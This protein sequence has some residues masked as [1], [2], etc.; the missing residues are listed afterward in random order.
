MS[1]KLKACPCESCVAMAVGWA[2]TDC[3]VALDKGNDPRKNDLA[4]VLERA[5]RDLNTRAEPEPSREAFVAEF[6]QFANEMLHELTRK[7]F[8]SRTHLIAIRMAEMTLSKLTQADDAGE[9]PIKCSCEYMPSGK[10]CLYC[11]ESIGLTPPE[12]GE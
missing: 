1:E 2:Y 10:K 5:K 4:D 3:C 8:D 12:G 6:V 7:D 11:L 9:G